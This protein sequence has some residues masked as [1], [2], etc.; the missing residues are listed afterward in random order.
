MGQEFLLSG[1]LVSQRAG[2]RSAPSS[3][4]TIYAGA[5]R[6]PAGTRIYNKTGSTARLCGDMGIL[7]AKDKLG[8]DHPYIVVGI[9]EKAHRCKNYSSWI[10][11]RGNLIREV[12]NLAYDAMKERYRL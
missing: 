2:F 10:A 7:V 12:S 3:N 8:Q 5:R 11:S 9:V 6:V 1:F 4:P